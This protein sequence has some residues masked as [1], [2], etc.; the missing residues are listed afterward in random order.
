MVKVV[1]NSGMREGKV[2]KRYGTKEKEGGVGVMVRRSVKKVRGEAKRKRGSMVK[3]VRVSSK[4]ER[5][6]QAG[7]KRMEKNGV[8]R[9][10]K[11]RERRA[12]RVTGVVAKE[13]RRKGFAKVRARATSVV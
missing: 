7:W 10:N 8:V 3:A 1:D 12:N 13:R 5:K 6:C 4:K 2:L 11:K 9:R